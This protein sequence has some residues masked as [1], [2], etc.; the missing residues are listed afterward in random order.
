MKKENQYFDYSVSSNEQICL[1]DSR[2]C[3][4]QIRAFNGGGSGG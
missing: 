3:N 1:Y 4:E 2:K